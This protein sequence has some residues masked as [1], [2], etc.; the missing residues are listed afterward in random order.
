[1]STQRPPVTPLLPRQ[2]SVY[3]IEVDAA[4]EPSSGRPVVYVGETALSPDERYTR[5]REGGR[6]ASAVVRRSGVSLRLDLSARTGPFATRENA[7]AAELRLAEDLRS[8]GFDVF[9]GQGR[10]F[11]LHAAVGG[12]A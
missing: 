3:V 4:A 10:T 7:E 5:H 6:T 1:M 2:Y 12:R 8:T 9:G 11:G